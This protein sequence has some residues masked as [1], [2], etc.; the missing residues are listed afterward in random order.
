ML[1]SGSEQFRRLCAVHSPIGVTVAAPTMAWTSWN[2][3]GC[4]GL[5]ET[6]VR[7]TADAMVNGGLLAA[8]YDTLTLDDC[9]SAVSRDASGNLTGRGGHRCS[10]RR[11]NPTRFRSLPLSS[12]HR[13][14]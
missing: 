2:S 7:E 14:S 4:A 12:W 3:F 11:A 10:A 13:W 1:V 9:W 6:L 8:G 5:T